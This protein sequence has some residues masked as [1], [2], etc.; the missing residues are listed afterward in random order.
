MP[1]GPASVLDVDADELSEDA[2]YVGYGIETGDVPVGP[3][4]V[5][6]DMPVPG[7]E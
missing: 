6:D 4:A 5:L 7:I 3:T 1:V 2:G